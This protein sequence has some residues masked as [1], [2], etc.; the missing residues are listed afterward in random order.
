MILRT[1]AMIISR[2]KEHEIFISEMD[3]KDFHNHDINKTQTAIFICHH[4]HHTCIPGLLCHY[5]YTMKWTVNM[6][7][8]F[9][10]S[11]N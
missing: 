2:P 9:T 5:D 3:T 1:L 6:L 11:F 7:D 4:L 10:P 8:F